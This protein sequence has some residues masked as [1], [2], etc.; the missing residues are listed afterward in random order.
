MKNKILLV[1]ALL[2]CFMV[3]GQDRKQK[4]TEWEQKFEQLGT[5][6]PTPNVYRTASGAPG[7]QYW[8]QKADYKMKIV[9]CQMKF[10]KR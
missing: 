7:H 3:S 6:L 2:T 5:M 8:Q 1:A 9:G 4:D 10:A